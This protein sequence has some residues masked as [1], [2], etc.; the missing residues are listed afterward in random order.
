MIDLHSK[1]IVGYSFG[2]NMTNDL[3]IAALK[4]ACYLQ[5]IG[6][7]NKIIFHSYLGSQYT[8]NDMKNLCNEFNIIQHFSQ[9]GDHYDN[10]CIKSFHAVLNKE[11]VYRNTYEKYEDTKKS[12]FQYIESF[13]NSKRLH[14]AL[15]YNTPNEVEFKTL[16]DA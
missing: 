4:N 8:S 9:K 1:K 11:E 10:A 6:K 7:D 15:D 5:D 16:N 13:Y 12:N 3:V 2:K 14:S